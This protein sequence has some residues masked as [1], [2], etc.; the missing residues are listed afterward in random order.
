MMSEYKHKKGYIH[1]FRAIHTYIFSSPYFFGQRLIIIIHYVNYKFP[2]SRCLIISHVSIST[3]KKK[4]FCCEGKNSFSKLIKMSYWFKT[5]CSD[6]CYFSIHCFIAWK[7][8]V[9]HLFGCRKTFLY[10][11][12]W[13]LLL[14]FHFWSI[15]ETENIYDFVGISFVKR[16]PGFSY[17]HSTRTS[18]NFKGCYS[19]FYMQ[20]VINLYLVNIGYWIFQ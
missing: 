15:H 8:T 13:L 19:S 1:V 7:C 10:I 6:F 5:T 17:V 4:I 14:A 18:S 20:R 3:S 9:L 11:R 2:E 16:N 12:Y